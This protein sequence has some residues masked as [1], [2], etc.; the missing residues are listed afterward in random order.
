MSLQQNINN[1]IYSIAHL[2]LLKSISKEPKDYKE[3]R[4]L[5]EDINAGKYAMT[6]EEVK[7][8]EKSY[9]PRKIKRDLENAEKE[10]QAEKKLEEEKNLMN[11]VNRLR[12]AKPKL[13]ADEAELLARENIAKKQ[14]E[15]EKSREIAQAKNE[16]KFAKNLER[17]HKH[18][19]LGF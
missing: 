4:Q 2:N 6:P 10:L 11:E 12:T 15:Y 7:K 17:A 14:A 16:K 1:S 5:I 19:K 13:T 18:G 8:A 3:M 9:H